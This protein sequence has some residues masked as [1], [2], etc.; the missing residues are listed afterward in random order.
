MCN[1][2]HNLMPASTIDRDSRLAIVLMPSNSSMN[3]SAVIALT[4]I[5]NQDQDI[6]LTQFWAVSLKV[7]R[8]NDGAHSEGTMLSLMLPCQVAVVPC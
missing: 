5:S 8:T 1:G 7:S 6:S 3:A 2:T 4:N